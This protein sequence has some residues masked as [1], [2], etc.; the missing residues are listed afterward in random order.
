M[1]G[2]K[3]CILTL[4]IL[5]ALLILMGAAT[6]L[7]DPYFHYHAPLPGLAY[8]LSDERQRYINDGI[9]KHFEYDAMLTGTSMME[10]SRSSTFD[11][12]F[13]VKS[14][15]VP[16][17][18]SS[19]KETDQNLCRAIEANPELKLVFRSLDYFLIIREK[20]EQLYPEDL[21]PRY[22]YDNNLFNDS[23][24]IFNK[25]VLLENTLPT[26]GRTLRGEK[27]TSFDDYSL[28]DKSLF[29]MTAPEKGFNPPA[30]GGGG[31]TDELLQ[32]VEG[33]IRQNVLETVQANPQIDFY[34]VISPYSVLYWDRLRAEGKVD[35]HLDCEQKAAE[36][37]VGEENVH[38][39]SFYDCPEIIGALE[40]Y[41]DECH[42]DEEIL[43]MIFGYMASEEH[44]LTEEN[45]AGAFD[46]ARELFKN[47][48]LSA[49]VQ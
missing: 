33:N 42:Y 9:S 46:R 29:G 26:I 39:F 27:M 48:D 43:D 49:M 1:T 22:L 2:K 8:E 4:A 25:T 28:M 31:A 38:I 12:L 24:Y 16:Y 7:I 13:G 3:W 18:G 47:G 19:L 44:R 17:E 30:Q 40:H 41:M 35:E 23:S 37:L 20:D 5:A 11:E 21:Y 32:K 15:K 36:L 14:V 34:F 6:A 45:C 10:N